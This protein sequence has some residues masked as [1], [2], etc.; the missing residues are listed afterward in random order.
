MLNFDD[1][2]VLTFDCYGTLIDWESGICEALDP[3]LTAH[4]AALPPDEMLELYGVLEAD[5]EGGA[6][7]T[8]KAVLRAVLEGFGAR[9]GFTATDAELD[10]FS[11]S[12]ENWRPFPDSPGALR[13]LKTKYSLA[14]VSNVDDDLFAHSARRLEVP[15]DY[16]ITAQQVQSYKPATAHFHEAFRRI[17]LPRTQ[18]LHVAQSLFHDIGVAKSLGLSTV[19]VNR[20]HDQGGTGATPPAS[21]KPDVEVPDLAS[22]A[23]LM[24]LLPDGE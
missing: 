8:Y 1:F 19:W 13:A 12:V 22:L 9:L 20:R 10:R 23:R 15:F 7:R 24:G 6:Y 5:I 18:I 17:G 4:N 3:V 16:V 14:I 21:A 2:A 11:H